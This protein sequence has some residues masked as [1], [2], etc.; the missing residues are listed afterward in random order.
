MVIQTTT[1][2]LGFFFSTFQRVLCLV[3]RV[4]RHCGPNIDPL[5]MSIGRELISLDDIPLDEP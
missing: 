2:P 4:E 5:E 3:L 1:T